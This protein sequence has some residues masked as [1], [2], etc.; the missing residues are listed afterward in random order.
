MALLPI[1]SGGEHLRPVPHNEISGHMF[2]KFN[3]DS[4]ATSRRTSTVGDAV[5]VPTI[6]SSPER[7]HT[8]GQKFPLD[9]YPRRLP[10]LHDSFPAGPKGGMPRYHTMQTMYQFDKGKRA[11]ELITNVD[12]SKSTNLKLPELDL[13]FP[14]DSSPPS[15]RSCGSE[16]STK[17]V[18]TYKSRLRQRG[19]TFHDAYSLKRNKTE[20]DTTKTDTAALQASKP[21]QMPPPLERKVT[22]INDRTLPKKKRSKYKVQMKVKYFSD[23][24]KG[25]LDDGNEMS[26][27]ESSK[28]MCDET[29]IMNTALERNFSELMEGYCDTQGMKKKKRNEGRK[30]GN[31]VSSQRMSQLLESENPI[32]MEAFYNHYL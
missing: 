15:G 32:K 19:L 20:K 2:I 16:I 1:S 28:T 24:D 13:V 17:Y 29:D 6:L 12:A 30:L 27:S 31:I 11:K 23:S 18:D 9:S 14:D 5:R 10:L 21:N 4:G 7:V 25:I 22:L 3:N 26:N 8:T